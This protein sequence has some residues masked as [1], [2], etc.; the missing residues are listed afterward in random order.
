MKKFH[1]QKEFWFV[2]VALISLSAALS[3]IDGSGHWFQG[4]LSY[5]LLLCLSAL[6]IYAILKLVGVNCKVLPILLT[7][8]S[9]RLGF[10]IALALLLPVVGYLNNN[11][12]LAGYI[13]T[14]AFNRD[15][16][17]WELASSPDP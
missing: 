17:A 9:L 2:L 4:W 10:G 3:A 13:Y 11:E 16:Q 15:N 5:L 7:S 14:D 8:Y 6:S 12:H 1:P